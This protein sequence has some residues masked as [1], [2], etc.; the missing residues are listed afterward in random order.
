[1]CESEKN[2]RIVQDGLNKRKEERK[3]AEEEARQEKIT[4]QMIDIVNRNA[5]KIDVQNKMEINRAAYA[6][7]KQ[8][9]DKMIAHILKKRDDALS[10]VFMALI[11]FAIIGI[12]YITE[13]TELLDII[14]AT[15]LTTIMFIV[16]SYFAVMYT[17]KGG[18]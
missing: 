9:R 8:K 17:I 14:A 6:K 15:V 12:C 13:I 16:S 3:S 4:T 2:R 5:H 10:V 18:K 1:M 11:L 7:Q